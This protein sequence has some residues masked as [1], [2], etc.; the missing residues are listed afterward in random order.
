MKRIRFCIVGRVLAVATVML[1]MVLVL[2]SGALAATKYTVLYTFTGGADGGLPEAGLI[3]DANGN[4]YGT[5]AYGGAHGVG[6]VFELTPNSDGNWTEN[7]LYSFTGGSDGGYPN[8]G[9]IF[10]T[11]GNLY[12]TTVYGPCTVFKLT[13]NSDGT[14]TESVIH[15]LSGSDGSYPTGGLTF[16]V[17]GNLYGM[18]TFGGN[19]GAGTVYRLT[20]NQD[21]SW[22]FGLLH[23]FTMGN[24]GGYPEHAA[25]IFDDAGN[26]Y[27]T[28]ADGGKGNC[29]W[30][31]G[32]RGCG[33][34]FELIPRA[35]GSWKENVLYRFLGG[36]DGGTAIGAL[37]ERAGSLYGA[38]YQR[39]AYAQ[40]NVFKLT[41]GAKGK[42]TEKVLHQFKGGEDGANSYG[43]FVFDK[44]G[45]LYGTTIAGGGSCNCGTVFMLTPHSHGAWIEKVLHRFDGVAGAS[46]SAWLLP[47]GHGSYYGATMNPNNAGVVFEITP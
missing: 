3:L 30:Q 15:T 7:V 18:T 22:T 20:P 23:S 24:D 36:N 42:W 4:L 1:I 26:L 13:P 11:N 29:D 2:A 16:D 37:I 46:P 43:G 25:L 28:T 5:A 44:T 40:G 38:T 6:A 8:A 35:H 31:G 45:N 9:L 47:D 17:K 41:R 19:Y 34:V 32:G 39:G 12:G 14:W 21:G 10:D 33:V 27:G